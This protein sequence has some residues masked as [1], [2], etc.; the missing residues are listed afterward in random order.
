MYLG[1]E[2]FMERIKAL[3]RDRASAFTGEHSKLQ[4]NFR[5]VDLATVVETVDA[6]FGGPLRPRSWRNELARS[7]F[8]L[9]ARQQAIP[10]LAAIGGVLGL[11]P[12]GTSRLIDRSEELRK[13]SKELEGVMIHLQLAITHATRNNSRNSQSLT[14]KVPCTTFGLKSSGMRIQSDS[15]KNTG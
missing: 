15:S 1:S 13:T 9:L 7:A 5:A 11:S 8:S 6:H 4:K 2:A 10:T 3:T 12:S 14:L